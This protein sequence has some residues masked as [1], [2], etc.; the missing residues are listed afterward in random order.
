MKTLEDLG[1]NYLDLYLIHWPIALKS[2]PDNFPRGED[3]TL[4]YSDIHYKETWKEMEKA[5]DE[6]LIKSIGILF[7]YV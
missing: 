3:G 7:F 6:G 5:V 2:G 1:L 4:L